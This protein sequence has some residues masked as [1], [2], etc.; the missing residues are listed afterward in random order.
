MLEA[1]ERIER[2]TNQGRDTFE[3]D[4]LLQTWIVHHLQILGEAA[5]SATS[6]FRDRHSNIAWKQIIGMRTILVHHYFDID[7][8]AIWLTVEQDLPL[9][10]LQILEIIALDNDD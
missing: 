4:E 9:L 10:K 6:A 3:Q 1:I 7:L 5:R 2:H 8:D